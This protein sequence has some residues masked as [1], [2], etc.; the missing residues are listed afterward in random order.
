MTNYNHVQAKL[1]DDYVF[2]GDGNQFRCSR[3]GEPRAL[4]EHDGFKPGNDAGHV[5]LD[6]NVRYDGK[7]GKPYQE[8]EPQKKEIAG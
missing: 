6:V 8:P 5:L 2:E 4:H 1:R 7:P 3:C